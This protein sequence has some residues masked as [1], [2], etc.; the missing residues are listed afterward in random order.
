VYEVYNGPQKNRNANA[1]G[2]QGKG[3]DCG[4][5]CPKHCSRLTSATTKLPTERNSFA[6]PVLSSQTAEEGMGAKAGKGMLVPRWLPEPSQVPIGF[7]R[8]GGHGDG[9]F[10]H[11]CWQ[12]GCQ[13]SAA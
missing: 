13:R 4:Q 9:H 5:D 7:H 1:L 3:Q 6:S 12:W 2:S 8:T 11:C 10:L